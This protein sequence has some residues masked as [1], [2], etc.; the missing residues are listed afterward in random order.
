MFPTGRGK[1]GRL[2]EIWDF[3]TDVCGSL[4]KEVINIVAVV[5]LPS[6][7]P[8]MFGEAAVTMVATVDELNKIALSNAPSKDNKFLHFVCKSVCL[9]HLHLWFALLALSVQ[10]K[11]ESQKW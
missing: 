6:N 3:I 10:V 5:D 7:N 8:K 11:G 1:E 2:P 9:G 4:S